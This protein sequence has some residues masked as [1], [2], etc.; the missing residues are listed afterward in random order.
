[1]GMTIVEKILARASSQKK[2]SPGDL[3]VV[4]VD[5]AVMLDTNFQPALRREILKV[6]DPEKIVLIY[7]HLVPAP[8]RD[9]A[10]AQ[11]MGRAFVK[12][13]GI[14]RFHD[15]GPEQGINHVVVSE[16]GYGL[17]GTVLVCSDSHACAAGATNCAGRGT[18][19]PDLLHAVTT[20]KT[21]FRIGGTV[22]YDRSGRLGPHVTAKDV[23]LHIAGTFG[24]HANLNVE[25]GG[26]A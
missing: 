9:A 5:T 4:D 11:A 16:R 17:P 7:D 14:K 22:S 10:D 24:D 25:Y 26:P 3:A 18:G 20:G 2:V 6:H 12:K 19:F 13:H 1:M 15:V 21:W 8:D 23:F